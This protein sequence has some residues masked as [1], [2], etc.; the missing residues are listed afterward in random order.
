MSHLLSLVSMVT[1]VVLVLN[2]ALFSS[3][4]SGEPVTDQLSPAGIAAVFMGLG[5]LILAAVCII[6]VVYI[7]CNKCKPL[8]KETKEL[9][10]V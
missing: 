8:Q 1:I 5:L 9:K 10:Y 2:S 3:T 4:P 6:L 7:V